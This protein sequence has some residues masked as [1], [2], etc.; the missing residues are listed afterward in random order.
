MVT[1]GHNKI[2]HFKF[3]RPWGRAD[4]DMAKQRSKS[5][6][7]LVIGGKFFDHLGTA[8]RIRTVIFGDDLNR[9]S[10]YAPSIIDDFGGCGGG[11]IIPAPIS[12]AYAGS[13]D[14]KSNSDRGRALGLNVWCKTRK[15][16][17]SASSG[18][19]CQNIPASGLYIEVFLNGHYNSPS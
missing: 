13:M 17:G 4:H 9:A 8:L 15:R 2:W 14:L 6:I 18:E 1:L 11:A 16:T 3:A 5:D 12:S 19:A 7:C 10:V